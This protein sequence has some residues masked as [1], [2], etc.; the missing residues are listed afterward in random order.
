MNAN[1]RECYNL[2]KHLNANA[3]KCIKYSSALNAN[4][5]NANPKCTE[6]K[7]RVG[8]VGSCD[9]KS[10]AC[11]ALVLAYEAGRF[12]RRDASEDNDDSDRFV[13]GR[14]RSASGMLAESCERSLR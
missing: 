14:S 9:E 2:A 3:V 4:A 8:S 13:H 5:Q 10:I 6:C 11:V 7:G 1:A 12:V